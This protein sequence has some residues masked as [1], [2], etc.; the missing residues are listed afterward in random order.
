MANSDKPTGLS[1][2]Q[3]NMGNFKMQRVYFDAD[4]ATAVFVGDAVKSDQTNGGDPKGEAPAVVQAA[5]G[6]AIGGILVG[7]EATDSARSTVKYRAASTAKYGIAIMSGLKNT[8]FEIQEDSVGGALT[9][10]DVGKYVD[11]IVGTGDTTT[12]YS[13]MEI[14]SSSAG[15]SDGQLV[16]IEPVQRPDNAI[17][18]NCKWRVQINES[19]FS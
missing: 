14:D 15:T 17:G 11:V 13:A 9:L 2:E 19:N 4:D 10:D 7:I 12:G 8:V 3:A 6:D 1:L 16:L 5:A 18:T